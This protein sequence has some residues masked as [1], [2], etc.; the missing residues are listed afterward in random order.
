MTEYFVSTRFIAEQTGL[1]RQRVLEYVRTKR[2][3]PSA[4]RGPHRAMQFTAAEA[5]RFIAAWRETSSSNPSGVRLADSEVA[6]ADA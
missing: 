4:Q 6:D 5:A 1:S 3:R 2:L